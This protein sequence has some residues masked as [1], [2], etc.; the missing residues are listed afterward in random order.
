ML[1]AAQTPEL[2]IDHDSDTTTQRFTL[3][4]AAILM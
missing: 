4:H 3:F 1:Y 2:P